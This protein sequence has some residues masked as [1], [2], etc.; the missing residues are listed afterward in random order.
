MSVSPKRVGRQEAMRGVADNK[1]LVE[2]LGQGIHKKSR[3]REKTP[4]AFMAHTQGPW[5]RP[6]AK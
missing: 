6:S 5:S 4:P 3:V 2:G 1:T